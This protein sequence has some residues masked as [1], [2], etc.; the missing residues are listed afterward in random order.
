MLSIKSDAQK[1][2]VESGFG[3]KFHDLNYLMLDFFFLSL[4]I[5]FEIYFLLNAL[6]T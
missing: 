1:Q 2:M 3:H 4:F 6:S 5:Y